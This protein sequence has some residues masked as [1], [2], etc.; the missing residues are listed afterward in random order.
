MEARLG[1]PGLRPSPVHGAAEPH[2]LAGELTNFPLHHPSLTL[3]SQQGRLEGVMEVRPGVWRRL[4][5]SVPVCE[6][7]SEPNTAGTLVAPYPS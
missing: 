7:V 1:W 2:R 3:G 4:G 6:L 5:L